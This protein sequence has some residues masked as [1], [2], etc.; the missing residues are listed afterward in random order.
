[1]MRS[2][3]LSS[4][5][6]CHAAWLVIFNSSLKLVDPK[7]INA[8]VLLNRTVARFTLTDSKQQ[9]VAAVSFAYA[10]NK[11]AGINGIIRRQPADHARYRQAPHAA[12]SPIFIVVFSP[13]KA[14]LT[15]A[16]TTSATAA[17]C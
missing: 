17:R 7:F 2:Q 9:S 14:Q 12:N 16:A 6:F 13:A 11:P 10:E 15:A 1:L 8:R 4:S 3:V 5:L